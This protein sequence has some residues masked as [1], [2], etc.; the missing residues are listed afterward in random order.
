MLPAQPLVMMILDVT[1]EAHGRFN[2]WGKTLDDEIVLL[3]VNDFLPYFYI[4]APTDQVTPPWH[5]VLSWL[6]L[7]QSPPPDENSLKARDLLN[8]MKLFRTCCTA[9]SLNFP[10]LLSLRARYMFSQRDEP[11]LARLGAKRLVVTA[12]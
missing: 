1:E 11:L 5:H 10:F 3:H 7:D 8:L 4:A 9:L 12:P 6:T 2:I